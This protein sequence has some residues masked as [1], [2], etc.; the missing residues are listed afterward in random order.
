MKPKKN[1][2]IYS[3]YEKMGEIE[4]GGLNFAKKTVGSVE[5]LGMQV[6]AVREH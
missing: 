5:T 2:Y 1:I 3:I 4:S 6:K